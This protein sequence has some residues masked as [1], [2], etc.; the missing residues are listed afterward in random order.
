[1]NS[2]QAYE[3]IRLPIIPF[4]PTP[5]IGQGI[6]EDK[7]LLVPRFNSIEGAINHFRI[8][9]APEK[10]THKRFYVIKEK[11][12]K[13]QVDYIW[14]LKPLQKIVVG[15]TINDLNAVKILIGNHA[16]HSLS[17]IRWEIY[18]DEDCEDL[19][20]IGRFDQ[21]DLLKDLSESEFYVLKDKGIIPN[22]NWDFDGM[23]FHKTCPICS[24]KI[25]INGYAFNIDSATCNNCGNRPFL[26]P[27]IMNILENIEQE[28][29]P[30][31]YGIINSNYISR[32]VNWMS[33]VQGNMKEILNSSEDDKKRIEKII[34]KTLMGIA[35]SDDNTYAKN[36]IEANSTISFE[37]F[38]MCAK[39]TLKA[40]C[41]EI[42]YTDEIQDTIKLA[43]TVNKS[44]ETKLLSTNAS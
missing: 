10:L 40:L 26:S 19:L 16:N 22:G 23:L 13:I 36:L 27:H 4:Q 14:N 31:R 30:G 24:T 34:S 7:L 44:V 35:I 38:K 8:N 9:H 42:E 28:A 32:L 2:I 11:G 29:L 3:N 21:F 43:L 41:G 18:A 15:S 1:M 25:S 39:N 5:L 37:F 17:Y 6:N 33:S 12:D 20:D